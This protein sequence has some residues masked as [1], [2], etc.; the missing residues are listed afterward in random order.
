[1]KNT[2]ALFMALGLTLPAI[3]LAQDDPRPGQRSPLNREGGPG[4]D[5]P[6]PVPPLMGALPTGVTRS[7]SGWKNGY[8]DT[9]TPKAK[10]SK[11]W[12]RGKRPE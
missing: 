5:G 6:R 10:S 4:P 9:L 12:V 3:A 2:L 8:P 1:M 11:S 7:L